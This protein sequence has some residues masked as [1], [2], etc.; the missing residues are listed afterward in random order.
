MTVRF[1]HAAD[2]HLDTP[3]TTRGRYPDHVTSVLRDA[4]LAAFTN[5]VEAALAEEVAFVVVAGDVYDG[6]RRGVR[7]QLE[8]RSG[9]ARLADA[10]I[11]SFVA[12]GNHDPVD[13]GWSAIDAFPGLVTVFGSDGVDSVAFATDGGPVTVH[14]ISFATSRVSENLSRRFSPPATPGLHVGV[15]HA[16]VGHD[17]EHA[18]YSPCTVDDLVSVGMHYWA[19]GHIHTRRVLHR[20]PWVVY[21]GNLQGRT[22]RASERGAKGAL[23]VEAVDARIAEPRFLPLDVVRFATAEVDATDLDLDGL[24][25]ALLEAGDAARIEADGR[26]VLLGGRVVG[27]GGLHHKLARPNMAADLLHALRDAAGTTD[28]FLWWDDLAV[29]TRPAIDLD[30]LRAGDDFA[31]D[32]LAAA[33]ALAGPVALDD[34]RPGWAGGVTSDIVRLAEADHGLPSVDELWPEAVDLALDL[35]VGDV[36]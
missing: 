8:L 31:A 16:N 3:F 29:A 21:P 33:G 13:E 28:P 36:P 20:Q 10:G 32:L 12:H 14:G 35:L 23:V 27:R 26:S 1:L 7:A 4:S 2:L 6:A 18:A 5:L 24:L 22:I 34:P 11:R 9:L 30:L 25:E 15:L 17:A 19:L